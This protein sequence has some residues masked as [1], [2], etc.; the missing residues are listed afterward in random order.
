MAITGVRML[1]IDGAEQG[2][3]LSLACTPKTTFHNLNKLL[4]DEF[5][6]MHFRIQINEASSVSL[7]KHSI[8]VIGDRSVLDAILPI[9]ALPLSVSANGEEIQL[10]VKDCEGK[11][12]VISIHESD[13]IATLKMLIEHDLGISKYDQVLTFPNGSIFFNEEDTILKLGVSNLSTIDVSVELKGGANPMGNRTS[14]MTDVFNDLAKR[15]R[16]WGSGPEWRTHRPGFVIGGICKSPRCTAFEKDV[17]CNKGFGSFNLS[18]T[19]PFCPICSKQVIGHNLYFNNCFFTVRAVN[20]ETREKKTLPWT[21]IGNFYRTWDSKIAGMKNWSFMQVVTREEAMAMRVPNNVLVH[22]APMS[23]DCSICF[24]WMEQVSDA[25]M[26]QC[27][28]SFHK[29]CWSKWKNNKSSNRVSVQC[30]NCHPSD[31]LRARHEE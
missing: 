20:A 14:A 11:S 6:D 12:T 27:C 22:E 3:I 26:L 4:L 2:R 5:G 21:R 7:C 31:G 17:R 18:K 15:D 24:K 9:N 13:S 30:P 19:K 1:L 29:S 10:R 23:R 16:N 28:H 25:C 8:K